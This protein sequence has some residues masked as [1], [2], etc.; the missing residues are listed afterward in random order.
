MLMP[1]AF[2]APPQT[3]SYQ[4]YLTNPAGTP[5]NSAVVMTFKLYNV[6]V[7]GAA[8]YAELQPS[9]AVSNGNFNAVIGALSPIPLPFDQ[10][11][12]LAVTINA[13][14]EMTPRQPLA[15][16]PYAF[17]ALSLDS[18]ATVAGSQVSGAITSATA[19]L[20][21]TNLTGSISSAQIANNAV[22]QSK[23]SPVS[24]AAAG[25][26]LG[27]DGS[28][29]QWQTAG[30]GTV[31]SIATGSGLS[32][33]PI[34]GSG[35]ISLAATQMLPA[36]QCALNQIPKWNGS[37]W[38]CAA[39][40]INAAGGNL[41]LAN[42]STA[43]TGNILKG[44]NRF[45][46]N[47]GSLNTF[48]GEN[49][50]NF[51]MTG[52]AN[53]VSGVNALA[54][55]T[56]GNFNTA[57]GW[58]ALAANS[59]GS[60][61]TATGINAL[62]ANTTGINNTGHGANALSANVTGI[63]NTAGGRSALASNT[64]GSQNTASGSSALQF[65]TTGA[66]NTA[67]GASALAANTT[68]NFNSASGSGALQ[69][70]TT[71]YENT[72]TGYLALQS[73]TTGAGNTANGNQTLANNADGGQNTATGYGALQSNTTAYSNTASGFNALNN[74]TTG[75]INTANGAYA[76]YRNITGF[77]NTGIGYS[78]LELNTTGNSN[79]AGG[80][81]ALQFNTTGSSN[82]AT[83]Y[84][85]L[86]SNTSG[87]GNTAIGGEALTVNTTGFDNIAV[88]FGALQRNL[89]GNSNIGVGPL[90]GALL[91]TGSN[92]IDI[93][94]AGA[95]GESGTIR[96]GRVGDQFLAYI[97]GIYNAPALANGA[98]VYVEPDGRLGTNPSSRRFKDNIT[99]MNAASSA[100][101]NL[102]PVTFHY[103]TDQHPSGRT[104]QYGLIAEEVAEV[105][106]GLIVHSADGEIDAVAYQHLPPMLLNEFQKQQR[107]IAAQA[108][109]LAQQRAKTDMLERKLLNIEAMLAGR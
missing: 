30:A 100:L 28:N 24:G 56:T 80:S 2:A 17:H 92:N 53:T 61:N 15:S 38:T 14:A 48:I 7:G 85:A 103:K 45:I 66:G 44:A 84:L 96:I 23:L 37:A 8:L 62:A 13:D 87:N 88:G 102:R 6:A 79:S 32:G 60:Q 72:A 91:T 3:I 25:K 64:T 43:T 98:T 95:A 81:G 33:G 51:T 78:A 68:G 58:N 29:L 36:V 65:N 75:I 76:L 31:T 21:T 74:N 18:A 63:N 71:G 11:Y 73:N 77:S 90:A 52:S 49:A 40:D 97:A 27:T 82:T 19:T 59:S 35:T 4:G 12:W 34:T 89:T 69:F 83:G 5:V 22:T 26:V 1:L 101:M 106:P 109:E 41:T 94:N 9:I 108:V 67:N 93:G 104:L 107:T 46:H 39:D 57:S 105:Y 20:P 47:F 55:N 16:T 10:P 86:Q 50:G 99:D 70:N 42:P 54:A